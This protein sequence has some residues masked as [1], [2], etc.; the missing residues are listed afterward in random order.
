MFCS[1][2][3]Q[4]D[5]GTS[6]NPWTR[7]SRENTVVKGMG[8]YP[9]DPSKLWGMCLAVFWGT[10]SRALISPTAASQ[11]QQLLF[12]TSSSAGVEIPPHPRECR[13]LAAEQGLSCPAW[14]QLR[15]QKGLELFNRWDLILGRCRQH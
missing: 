7:I 9:G 14:A 3:P 11:G 12:S 8:I 4:L 2:R 1:P 10:E 6:K 5:L 13:A 15:S